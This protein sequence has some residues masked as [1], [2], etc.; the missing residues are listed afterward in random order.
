MFV[1]QGKDNV[2]FVFVFSLSRTV[3]GDNFTRDKFT[4][5]TKGCLAMSGDIFVVMDG[6][7]AT[8]I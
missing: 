1:Y 3:I 2:L 7:D 4:L 6:R 8:G 5:P